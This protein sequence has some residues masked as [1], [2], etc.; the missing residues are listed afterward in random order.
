MGKV[1][2]DISMSLDGYISGQNDSQIQPLGDGGEFIQ[3][4][5]FDGNESSSYND[6]FKLSSTNKKVFDNTVANT[7]AMIVGRRTFD[8]VKGWGGSH[9]I[10]GIPIFVVTHQKPDSYIEE[11]TTFTFVTDGIKS[12]V[13]QAKKAAQDKNI[14]IGTAHIAQQ[15][16]QEGLLDEMLLHVSPVLLGGGIRLFEQNSKV[17]L[18]NIETIAAD[19]VTHLK[20]S[21]LY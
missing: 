18:K 10:Q 7:G 1:V 5:L 15:C 16:I 12:A 20:Y 11:N 8:I 19:N 9:P 3:N 21:L 4:W 17:K 2:L 6:F 13:E 14:S